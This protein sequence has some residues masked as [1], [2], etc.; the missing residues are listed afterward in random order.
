MNISDSEEGLKK[1]HSSIDFL[2]ELKNI[3]FLDNPVGDEKKNIKNIKDKKISLLEIINRDQY[4]ITPDNFRKMILILYR[5]IAK[6]P[7]ILM[8]ETGCGKTAL[9]KKLNQLLN[10]GEETLKIINVN[11]GTTDKIIIDTM[12]E[13]NDIETEKEIWVFFDEL[14]TCNSL[15]LL[16][17]IFIKRSFNGQ[18]LRKNIRLIGACNP[19][20]LKKENEIICG[21]TDPNDENGLRYNVNILPQ[22]LMYYVF[23]FSSIGKEDE[24][25]YISSII[26]ELFN[27]EEI[28]LKEKT[29]NLISESHS[30]LK[31]EF[32]ESVVSLREMTR[33][34]KC[35]NF[36]VNEYFPKKKIVTMKEDN[37]IAEKLKSIIISIYIC[38]YIRLID[39]Q[40]RK[41]FDGQLQ[42]FFVELVNY[43]SNKKID[44]SIKQNLIDKIEDPLKSVLKND[45]KTTNFNHFIQI[46]EYE[47]KYL[48]EQ[49]DLGKGIGDNKLLRENIFLL[50]ISLVTSIPLIIIGKP[51]SGKSLSA[52]LVCKAMKGKYSDKLFFKEFPQIFQSYFQ[53]SHSTTP[54]DV[55]GIFQIAE[56]KRETLIN[57]NEQDLPISMILFDELGL[58]ERSKSNPLKV[59]HSKL[60]YREDKK[61]VSFIGISNWALDASKMN[62]ALILSVKDLDESI[63]DL[64]KTAE[65]I[66]RSINNSL[67]NDEILKQFLPT[68]YFKYKEFLKNLKLLSVYKKFEIEEFNK[69]IKTKLAEEEFKSLFPNKKQTDKI[70]FDEFKKQ[71][72]KINNII[73]EKKNNNESWKNIDISWLKNNFIDVQKNKIFKK[74][75]KQDKKINIDFHGNRDFYYLIKGI[76][77]DFNTMNNND[78][79]NLKYEIVEKYIRRNFGG[80]EIEID[81]DDKEFEEFMD[82]ISIID[83]LKKKKENERF[84]S[85]LLFIEIYNKYQ[86]NNCIIEE[87]TIKNNDFLKN[88]INNINDSNSRYL[89]LQIKPSLGPL[90][91]QNIKDHFENGKTI[92]YEGS[93]FINDN[94]VEYQSKMISLIQ[95]N[96]GKDY[97]IVLQ[98]LNQIYPFLY[99][100][101]NM[102]YTYKDGKK[103]ARI[104]HGN[105]SDQLVYIHDSFRLVV[106]VDKK[107]INSAEPPFINRFE[108][109]II[110]SD[111]MLDNSKKNLADSICEELNIKSLINKSYKINYQIKDLLIG[112]K[113]QDIQGLIYNFCNKRKNR[114]AINEDENQIKEK[115]LNKIVK[116]I[117]QDIIVNIH[118]D[119]VLKEF[120]YKQAIYNTL[121]NYLKDDGSKYLISIIYTFSNISSNIN[122]VEELNFNFFSLIKSEDQLKKSINGMIET[123]KNQKYNQKTTIFFHF[124]HNDSKKLNFVIP[125]LKNNYGEDRIKFVIIIHLKRNFILNKNERI[126][127]VLDIYP[128][129]DQFFIDNLNGRKI[130]LKDLLTKSV[131]EIINIDGVLDFDKEFEKII[132]KFI[133]NN[134]N[135]FSNL[136][137][138]IDS[139]EYSQKLINYFKNDNILEEIKKKTNSF[140]EKYNDDFIENIYKDNF[141][142]KNSID[143]VSI[144]IDYIKD[145]IYSEYI[146]YIFSALEDKNILTSLLNLDEK[147]ELLNKELITEIKEESLKNIDFKKG[148][149]F[150]LKLDYDFFIPGFYYFYRDLSNFI[151]KESKIADEYKRF[152]KTI[153]KLKNGDIKD[154]QKKFYEKESS[155]LLALYDYLQK[156][157]FIFNF[158]NK[159]CPNS[160]DLLL[161]EYI[162][163]YLKKIDKDIIF[164]NLPF[165]DIY[166]KLV[167]LLLD[168]RYNEE[169]KIIEDNKDDKIKLFLIKII[170]LESNINYIQKIIQ[171]YKILNNIFSDNNK[172]FNLVEEIIKNKNI[173]YI[174]NEDKNPEHT[175]EVNECF[176]I[177]LAAIC[178]SV[179]PDNINFK[180]T[181]QNFYFSSLKK[182]LKIINNLNEELLIFLNEMYIIDEL[183]KVYDVLLINNKCNSNA[184][185][186]ITKNLKNNSEIL[187]SNDENI[188]EKL[189]E[190]FLEL[191]ELIKRYLT[192]EDKEYHNLLYY[193][194]YKEIKKIKNNNYRSVIFSKLI[195]E[196]ETITNIN[197]ILNLLFKSLI[198]PAKDKKGNLD[199]FK[200]TKNNL[201][202]DKNDILNII[203][204]ELEKNPNKISFSETLLYFFEKNSHIY[205][206]NV[207]NSPKNNL[208]E[209]DPLEIFKDSVSFLN[210]LIKNSDKLNNFNKNIAKLFCIAYIKSFCYI[211]ISL[212]NNK[213]EEFESQV[214]IINQINSS[215]KMKKIISLYIFKIIYYQNKR[216]ID[217]FV[218]PECN[219][220]YKLDKYE[221]FKDFIINTKENPFTYKYMIPNE[222]KGNEYDIFYNLLEK[223]QTTKFEDINLEDFQ[224]K[225]LDIDIF[226][227]SSCNMI[228]SC[229]KYKDFDYSPYYINFYKNICVPLFK[230]N[231]RIFTAIQFLYNPEKYEN[232]K[233][234]FKINSDNLE[235]LLYSYR[236]CLNELNS[237]FSSSIFGFLYNKKN[238]EKVH[239]YYFPGNDIRMNI[240][241]YELYSKIKSHFINKKSNETCFACLCQNGYYHSVIEGKIN[242]NL[243]KKCKECGKS[244]GYEKTKYNSISK[245]VKREN[246]YRIFESQEEC[247]NANYKILYN[248]MT[249]DEFKINYVYKLFREEKGITKVN[250]DHFKRDN[251]IIRNLSQVSYRLLNFIL[252]SHL[253]FAR[254]YTNNTKYDN[255]LPEKMDWLGVIS[256]CWELLKL[257]LN[258][259]GINSIDIFMNYIFFDLFEMLNKKEIISDFESFINYE[260]LLEKLIIGKIKKFKSQYKK[261]KNALKKFNKK[262]KF[263]YEYLLAEDYEDIDSTD[264]PYY[265][266]FNYSDYINEDYLL[267]ILNHNQKDKYP[268][269]KRYLEYYNSKKEKNNYS[270]DNLNNYNNIL[271]KFNEYY[272]HLIERGKAKEIILEEAEIYKGDNKELIDE[273]IAFYNSLKIQTKEKELSLS[274][275]S[276]LCDFFID[277]SNDIGKSYKDIY[278]KF[279]N[280]QNNQISNLLDIKIEKGIFDDE[281]KIKINIQD[282]NEDEIFSFKTRKKFSF[283]DIVFNSSYRK[284]ILDNNYKSYNLFNIDI[285]LIEERIT[286]ELLKG[287]K[288]LN[289]TISD[290]VY[291]NEDL[292]FE[293]IYLLTTFKKEYSEHSNIN[294]NDKV[295]L[296]TFYQNN[297]ENGNR[298]ILLSLIDDFI[299][300]IKNITN[301][302]GKK[303]ANYDNT[304]NESIK[305]SEYLLTLNNRVSEN[306]I[307]LFKDKDFTVNKLASLFEF[308]LILTF[309]IIKDKLQDYQDETNE[310]QK[311]NL[312]VYLEKLENNHDITK[313]DLTNAI[314][315]F[316]SLFLSK[317][318]DKEN[319]ISKNYNNIAKHL[320]IPDLWCSKIYKNKEKL[321]KELNEIKKLNIQIN[322]SISFYELLD[323]NIDEKY[324]AEI[325]E[326]IK[327]NK[328]EKK[329]NEEKI[330]RE[331]NEQNK[332][333]QNEQNKEK[334]NITNSP[335]ISQKD[336][337]EQKTKEEDESDED[338]DPNQYYQDS[339]NEDD[340]DDEDRD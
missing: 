338:F 158:I 279:I 337:D 35:C 84:S 169:H 88:V 55:E 127:S 273:F 245:P 290:F 131:K 223:Y 107:F 7:V 280:E 187:Q 145:K 47:E 21:L 282:I 207:I 136:S 272:S 90:I 192:F 53:G 137:T 105:F 2:R 303:K 20:R 151:T 321:N 288:L 54:E 24:K 177:I 217:V 178:L 191:Y 197:D 259:I 111:K 182:G 63:D 12:K 235:I 126:Y 210:N 112:C 340:D 198:K 144:I 291:K 14:N 9:I 325:K 31:K 318:K 48:I 93:P 277:D 162:T 184:I 215:K 339:N 11:P 327:R 231:N 159:I 281:C 170:W 227:F 99:D 134:I 81:I 154:K 284:I 89:L 308:Y 203:E 147:K 262:D 45:M 296:Y 278:T 61:K 258:K 163:F 33:F 25:K 157:D 79:I 211:F 43:N 254:L 117:P 193:I 46:L 301:S 125:F 68:T 40:S 297:I 261:Y 239:N 174:T 224:I 183:I 234:E 286:E 233:N 319:K 59:L 287:K 10:N 133:N 293:N 3:L 336:K 236:Y 17:E 1:Y 15:S 298:N 118:E 253:F 283:I 238:V 96:A 190:V 212:I 160:L 188:F 221:Y 110:S 313:E 185:E 129:V 8:G 304:I 167:I 75:Y 109:V 64:S 130:L 135:S 196:N 222:K 247:D 36:F 83:Y 152:E 173:R 52:Q 128:Y 98:N 263:F 240:K 195:E 119:N 141:I 124:D 97:L 175:T 333:E 77:N 92:F 123:N 120:Y 146:I 122:D 165:N 140:I 201:L 332:K 168:L 138:E 38:Y 260:D 4:V 213:S 5:I 150:S 295:F 49:I 72:K 100:L 202:N 143:M 37:V 142:N 32:G 289:D 76:A 229:L 94:G 189:I 276:K 180:E 74:L 310:E 44:D 274:V 28:N 26:S 323:E 244:I 216:K 309:E 29:A 16:T 230:I 299:I 271:N 73:T 115:V 331:K 166:H 248:D 334:D 172:L 82:T 256:E 294:I 86:K 186:E 218:K 50:F 250:V 116:I 225:D 219:K 6:I 204:N 62:R 249:I 243:V 314:R 237:N 148:K 67:S 27:D 307:N 300:T 264:Y 121:D 87:N 270:L 13:I 65:S 257:E 220:K 69:N 275:K 241:Y 324:F 85:E 205:L 199:K 176:Y 232:N 214:N 312:K 70:E 305:I 322:Q 132:N 42:H 56:Q 58:A 316:I 102:N 155:L 18:K 106:M 19:Y 66:V 156:D 329:L 91:Y 41:E 39:D 302:I 255:Y 71:I 320:N 335:I 22:S 251:K 108:K 265:T 179:L 269:L 181:D 228:L 200:N 311:N 34:K 208:L 268:V 149:E 317:E 60:E 57:K 292:S 95:D 267:S 242:K 161:N 23:N 164:K 194:F 246:Y 326:K 206:T 285:E 30:F 209:G 315:L 252:Y 113:K 266:Y 226:Y 114:I 80:T 51:G 153:R 103:Y 330:E 78:Y 101:F 328:I 306:F 139:D 104:C 171:L